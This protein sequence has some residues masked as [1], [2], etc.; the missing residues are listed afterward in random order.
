MFATIREFTELEPNGI[1]LIGDANSANGLTGNP[2]I[3]SNDEPAGN[4]QQR[5]DKKGY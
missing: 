2:V 1:N 5:M 3:D 4:N